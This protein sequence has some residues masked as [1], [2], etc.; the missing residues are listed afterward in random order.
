MMVP[1][2]QNSAGTDRK[3]FGENPV[4]LRLTA[5]KLIFLPENK[6][7]RIKPRKM[8]QMNCTLYGRKGLW[9]SQITVVVVFRKFSKQPD[10]LKCF[11][12]PTAKSAPSALRNFTRHLFR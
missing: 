12:A 11:K 1:P 2:V 5:T 6:N 3:I 10:D 7:S 9:F 8:A 4:G